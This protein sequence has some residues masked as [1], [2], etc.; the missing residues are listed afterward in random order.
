MRTAL[1][2]VRS[3]FSIPLPRFALWTNEV[4]VSAVSRVL[5]LGLFA[6]AAW[7]LPFIRIGWIVIQPS[8]ILF[9]RFALRPNAGKHSNNSNGGLDRLFRR[10]PR[11]PCGQRVLPEWVHKI[12]RP[13]VDVRMF[14]ACATNWISTQ[15]CSC[16]RI[17]ETRAVIMQPDFGV[18]LTPGEGVARR[19]RAQ[20]QTRPTGR[21]H[22]PA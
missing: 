12:R 14:G 22:V 18:P 3:A 6:P 19:A 13:R 10:Q 4:P 1:L 20:Q 7:Q 21:I 9:F 11:E 17:V 8:L 15:E 16:R 5:G 2:P